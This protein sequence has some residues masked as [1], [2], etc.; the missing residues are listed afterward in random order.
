MENQRRLPENIRIVWAIA[1]KDMGDAIRN[2][3][4]ISII[5]G[6]ALLMLSGQAMPLLMKLQALPRAYYYDVGHSNLLPGLAKSEDYQLVKLSSRDELEKIVAESSGTV[7]GLIIPPDFDQKVNGDEIVSLDGWVVHWAKSKDVEGAVSFFEQELS[8]GS[9]ASLEINIQGNVVYPGPDT[10][11]QPFMFTLSLVVAAITIG[12]FLIPLL[13]IEEK[14]KHT[15]E[16]LMVSPASYGQMVFGKTIAGIFYCVTA[17]TVVLVINFSMVNH[18]W[19]AILAVLGGAFFTAAIG[20]LV[21]TLFEH[22]GIMNMWLGLILILLIMP[23]FLEQTLGSR[24]PE[25]V[26]AIVPWLPSVAMSELFRMSLS[27][28]L[29][30]DQIV[31]NLGIMLGFT[32]LLLAV[33]VW[34][35][36]QLDR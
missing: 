5:V 35:V 22:Q 14:E 27:N 24:L 36:K 13:M 12:S 20:L 6:V 33:V 3:T 4:T 10:D 28:S 34:R 11:G 18:W 21:G 15:M 23:V 17:A 8:G 9:G 29:V 19:V 25:A 7:L 32:A 16:A 2:K 1:A 26:A 31:L 30:P